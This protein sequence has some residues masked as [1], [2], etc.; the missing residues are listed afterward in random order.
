[1]VEDVNQNNRVSD[2]FVEDGSFLRL[3]N[4]QL[5]YN[6]SPDVIENIGLTNAKIYVSG[7]N[8]LTL[9]GYS[10]MDPEI[11][12][13]TDIDGNG[14]VQS[15]GVDFGAYPSPQTFTVGVNLQF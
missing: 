15:R 12:S 6:L 13:V 14:G 8:L 4:I 11:G 1:M 10:G 2:H 7:Q 3:R 9:T 5:A